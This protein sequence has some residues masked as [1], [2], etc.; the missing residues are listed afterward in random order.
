MA[1]TWPTAAGKPLS[2]A[3][4][5]RVGFAELPGSPQAY[6]ALGKAWEPLGEGVDPHVPL[7][8]VAGRIGVV[9]AHAAHTDAAVELLLWL[10]A[11]PWGRQVCPVSAATTLFR[12]SQLKSPRQWTEPLVSPAAAAQYAALTAKTLRRSEY[13]LAVRLPGRAEYLAALAEAVRS[14][15]I[16]KS[17]PAD[18]LRTAAVHW[19]EITTRLGAQRQRTAYRQSLGVD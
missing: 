16:G 4:E 13:L 7:L 10:S 5:I 8:G 11:D 6:N 18:A 15:V 3:K 9:S 14:A 12:R 19:R 17:P 1:L 2:A